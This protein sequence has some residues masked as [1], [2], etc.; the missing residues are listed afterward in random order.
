M[1][2]QY[3]SWALSLLGAWNLYLAGKKDWRAWLVVLF[4]EIIWLVYTFIT[5]QYGFL[6]GVAIYSVLAT[7][8][9]LIWRREDKNAL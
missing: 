9:L 8:N 1:V 6:V 3:W 5:G 7:R 2:A 4:A